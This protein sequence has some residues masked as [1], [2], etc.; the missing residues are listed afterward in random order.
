LLGLFLLSEPDDWFP[1]SL[2]IVILTGCILLAALLAIKQGTAG[3]T[4]IIVC[5]VLFGLSLVYKDWFYGISTGDWW[6]DLL[7][8]LVISTIG[9]AI[10][11][12]D[13]HRA[14]S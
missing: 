11:W 10:R 7:I 13:R 1:G 6:E 12:L 8:G 5:G 14:A 4:L 2:P 9:A 3:G